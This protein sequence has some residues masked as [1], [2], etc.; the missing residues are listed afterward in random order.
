MNRTA[1][2]FPGL[3]KHYEENELAVHDQETQDL[4]DKYQRFETKYKE[5][6]RNTLNWYRLFS[7]HLKFICCWNDKKIL[8]HLYDICLVQ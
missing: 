3:Q 8:F 6:N 7:N 1:S 4:A 5:F 2:S